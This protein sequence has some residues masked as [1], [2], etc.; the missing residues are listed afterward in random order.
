[1]KTLLHST[2]VGSGVGFTNVFKNKFKE[3]LPSN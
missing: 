1:V 3:Y 2:V